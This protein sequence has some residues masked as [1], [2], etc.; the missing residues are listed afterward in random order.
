M[1]SEHGPHHSDGSSSAPLNALTSK[2]MNHR[3]QNSKNKK[4]T[5]RDIRGELVH[6][7]GCISE[8]P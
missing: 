7:E 3:I 1:P 4:G 8:I 6:C 2:T 5:E